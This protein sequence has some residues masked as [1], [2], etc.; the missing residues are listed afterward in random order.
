V[1]AFDKDLA[2]HQY[3]ETTFSHESRLQLIHDSFANMRQQL[4]SMGLLGKV[5][6]IM[7]DLGVSSPQLDEAARGFSFMQDGPL[8]MRMN[9]AQSLSAAVFLAEASVSEIAR[10]IHVY[11]EEKFARLIASKIVE[12]RVTHPFETTKQLADFVEAVIPTRAQN[13]K[14]GSKSKHPATRTFQAIRIHI[15]EE[16][17]D[18]EQLLS[19]AIK[20]LK[21]GGRLAVISFHSLEDRMVKRF[22]KTQEKGPVVPR[23]IPVIDIARPEHFV[24]VGKAIK[25]GDLELG[26]NVRSRSAVLRVAEKV[27]AVDGVIVEVSK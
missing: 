10:V 26:E 17:A 20:I 16:L 12:R 4:D 21:V 6:G 13:K 14:P 2:A 7:L 23:N 27:A 25:A 8:D 18:V 5:D 3:A 19:D 11:G 9:Q 15:N 24:S 1:I 22:I